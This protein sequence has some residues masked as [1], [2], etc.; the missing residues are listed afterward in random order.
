MRNC[1]ATHVLE[2]DE[3]QDRQHEADQPDEC[4]GRKVR[5][6]SERR[7]GE[8]WPPLLRM[9][10]QRADGWAKTRPDRACDR[11]DS[12]GTRFGRSA[13][14]NMQSAPMLVESDT[15]RHERISMLAPHLR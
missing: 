10:E 2:D 8:A 12:E 4:A 1:R 13:C 7:A 15:C 6:A 5:I 14:H 11:E 3:T 9:G